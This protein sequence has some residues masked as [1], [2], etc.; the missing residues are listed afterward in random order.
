MTAELYSSAAKREERPITGLF[1]CSNNLQTNVI[2]APLQ[3]WRCEVVFCRVG[4]WRRRVRTSRRSGSLDFLKSDGWTAESRRI[5]LTAQLMLHTQT[6]IGKI[7]LWTSLKKQHRLTPDIILLHQHLLKHLSLVAFQ[8]VSCDCCW[9]QATK[10]NRLRLT[11]D[12]VH[13]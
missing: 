7:C 3:S 13:G 11:E 9:V 10:T 12:C 1:Y 5:P 2:M 6:L 4:Q 8:N